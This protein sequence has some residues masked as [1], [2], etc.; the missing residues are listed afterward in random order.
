V[1]G[2]LIYKLC[3]SAHIP[4]KKGAK[5]KRIFQ[6]QL[7]KFCH[8]DHNINRGA[9]LQIGT[10]YGYRNIEKTE[11]RDEAEGQYE[12]TIEFPEEIELDRRWTNLL[13]QSLFAFGKSDDTPRFPGSF[14]A[15][16]VKI[17]IV[18]QIGDTVVVKDTTVRVNRSV[19]NSLIFCMSLFETAESNPFQNYKDH[20]AFGEESANEFARRLGNLIFQQAK[21]S[22]FETSVLETLSPATVNA[23]SIRVQHKKIRYGD[24]RLRITNQSKPS[25]E[26]LLEILSD[27]SFIK[28]GRFKK[29]NEYRFVFDLHD[30]QRLFP[31][32]QQNLLLTL[33]PLIDL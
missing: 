21:L 31:P 32:K 6:M 28:P 17:N 3:T 27:I 12:F 1:T 9:K 23:L 25:Y 2:Q 4:T 13:F 18:R 29:E 14:S 8:P 16:I 10:L 22:T 15:D 5:D 7:I 33:N 11:L 20:W 30:G 19:N 26:E 24:R